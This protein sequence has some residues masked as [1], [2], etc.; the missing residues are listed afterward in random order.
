[1][2]AGWSRRSRWHPARLAGRS[3]DTTGGAGT[4]TNDGFDIVFGCT[5]GYQNPMC[6]VAEDNP[7]TYFEHN[8]G[9]RTRENMGRYVGRI[10]QAR[11]LAG[12]AAGMVTEDDSLGYVAAFPIPE[13]VPGINADTLGA[14]SV[15]DAVT[16]KVRRTNSWFDP[17]SESEAANALVDEDVDVMAQHQ[18][19]PAALT[20]AAA[21][22][23][24]TGDD[25]RMGDQAGENYLTSPIW[26]WEEFYGPTLQAVYDDEWVPD[27]YWAG[28][29]SGICSLDE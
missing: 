9:Y 19:S 7:D 15:N 8:T 3:G 14:R 10:Y 21:D 25:A 20:A 27:S 2:S 13:V 17:P 12:Q 4:T 18:D 1:V 24:A 26:H 29:D 22:I 28:V 6:T 5:F 23:W 16:T 11:Y